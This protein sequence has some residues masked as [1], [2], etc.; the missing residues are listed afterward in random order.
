MTDKTDAV[1]LPDRDE[2]VNAAREVIDLLRAK[3]YPIRIAREILNIAND[4]LD[5][6]PLRFPKPVYKIKGEA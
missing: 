1:I 3:G 4:R 6:E 5:M 2:K